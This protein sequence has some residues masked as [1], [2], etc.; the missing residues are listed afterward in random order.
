[1]PILFFVAYSKAST[2]SSTSVLTANTAAFNFDYF[3]ALP[4]ND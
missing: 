3:E 1:M 2:T 4:Q